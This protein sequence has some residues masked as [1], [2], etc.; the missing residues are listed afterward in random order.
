MNI[1]VDLTNSDVLQAMLAHSQGHLDRFRASMPPTGGPQMQWFEE[2]GADMHMA[3]RH[4]EALEHALQAVQT[5][6]MLASTIRFAHG[7]IVN[8][9]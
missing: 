1:D 9:R 3:M 5:V 8:Q 2:H 4:V 7:A 6:N